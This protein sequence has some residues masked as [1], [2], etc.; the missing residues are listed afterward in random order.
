[1]KSPD[2]TVDSGEVAK[3]AAMAEAWWDP[4]GV[5]RPL[6]AMT[7]CR[8]DYIVRQIDG[9]F[10]CDPAVRRRFEGLRILDVGCGGGLLAEPM[11][12][13]GA[14]VTG[15]DASEESIRVARAHAEVSGLTI[16]YRASTVE[17]LVADQQ[18]FDVVLASEVIEHV[19]DPAGFLAAAARLVRPGGLLILSTLNRTARSY[20]LAIVGAEYVLGW[21]PRGTHDWSRF[22]APEEVASHSARAGLDWLDANGIV[23]DPGRSAFRLS[24]RDLSVNW[25]GTAR[26]PE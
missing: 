11:A 12:R 9:E 6:H 20:A 21:L 19:V 23:F 8:L 13:L 17:A 16:D 14:E 2:T 25:I 15:I 5:F 4:D 1:M 18:L 10:G 26:Q 22:L 3:F 24:D 7:P